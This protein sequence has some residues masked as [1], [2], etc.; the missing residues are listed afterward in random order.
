MKKERKGK[1]FTLK[2]ARRMSF[3]DSYPKTSTPRGQWSLERFG[4]GNEGTGGSGEEERKGKGRRKRKQSIK[5]DGNGGVL[6]GYEM[7]PT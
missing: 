3:E 2:N 7:G 5:I 6:I 4:K 1:N